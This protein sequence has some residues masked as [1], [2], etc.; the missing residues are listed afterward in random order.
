MTK[1][2][3]QDEKIGRKVSCQGCGARILY[4]K[5]DVHSQTYSS[6]GETEVCYDIKCP[7]CNKTVEVKAWY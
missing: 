5:N 2:I 4:Y 1:V 3:G 7:N 6:W